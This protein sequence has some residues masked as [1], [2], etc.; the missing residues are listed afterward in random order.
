MLKK[1]LRI[2]GL[3]PGSRYL[4]MAVFQGP[5]LRDWG[6]KVVKGRWS[7]AKL[8]KIK[9]I[10]L[11]TID[12]YGVNIL[13]VKR[14]HPSRSSTNLQGLVAEL[15]CLSRR[16]GLKIFFY[17]L[18]ELESWFSKGKRINKKTLAV[19]LAQEY[20]PLYYELEKE[21]KNRNPYFWRL[22]EAVALGAVGYYQN[23]K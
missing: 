22:F 15:T 8:K 11:R 5:E 17:S 19:M 6:V 3:N 14:L 16:K 12:Q 10:V 7:K 9:E 13:A 21:R 18:Q 4:G 2:L 23:E 1:P 20:P